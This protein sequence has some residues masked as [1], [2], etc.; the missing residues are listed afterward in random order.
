[1]SYRTILTC[2][3]TTKTVSQGTGT[4]TP[5]VFTFG[6]SATIGLRLAKSVN[7]AAVETSFDVSSLKASVGLVDARPTGGTWRLKIGP[8]AQTN[9]NT[10]PAQQANAPANTIASA[11]NALTGI[12]ATYGTATVTEQDGSWLITFA[13]ATAAVPL[14]VVANRLTPVSLGRVTAYEV[15]GRWI[16]ELRLIQTP[17]AFTSTSS[18]VLPDAPSIERI[19]AGGMESEIEFNE[20]QE[21]T[22]PQEFR[23]TYYLK[24]GGVRTGLLS[25]ADGPDEI[26]AALAIYGDGFEVTNPRPQKARIEFINDLGGLP[27]DLFEVHVADVPEGDLTFTLAFDRAELAAYLRTAAVAT[28]PLEVRLVIEDQEIVAFVVP[29]SIRRPVAF[30]ELEETPAIDWLRP[31]SPTQY[32]AYDPTQTLEGQKFYPAE[33]GDGEATVIPISHGLDTEY[34]WVWV[35]ENTNGGR[36]LI[37]GTDFTVTINN[38]NEVTVTALDGAPA[39]NA[40]LAIVMSANTVAHFANGLTVG[41]DQVTDLRDLLDA[42]G[43]DI[44]ELQTLL[45]TNA[46]LASTTAV[47]ALTI[48]FPEK[49]EVLFTGETDP[50]RLPARGPYLLPAVHKASPVVWTGTPLPAAAAESVWANGSGDRVLIPGG[51]M[52]RSG[53]AGSSLVALTGAVTATKDSAAVSGSGTAFTT[54]LFAGAMIKIGSDIYQVLSIT[55]ATALTLKTIAAANANGVTAYALT[56]YF[57]SDGRILYPASRDGTSTS[58]YPTAFE[59]TLWNVFVNEKQFASGTTLTAWF[60]LSLQLIAATC[61]A[62]WVLVIEK[63]TAPQDA[64]PATPGLNLH[65][66]DWDLTTPLVKQRL[67]LTPNEETHTFGCQ[68]ARSGS[69]FTANGYYYKQIVAVASPGITSGDIALRARLIQ[70]DTENAAVAPRGWVRYSLQKITGQTLGITIA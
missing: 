26:K 60:K 47:E 56:G 64:S 59:R 52:I 8:G 31:L 30:P 34:V 2:N 5:P 28:L 44:T 39:L 41:I 4:W 24:W 50:A 6:E 18:R 25:T 49:T 15:D 13:S 66:I 67:I 7:G 62:Q 42:M 1:M 51:G 65:D 46:S 54:E 69:T 61:D 70:F 9:A 37:D 53:Y 11:I 27:Q 10:I 43:A 16:N 3:L 55:S 17:V 32:I 12:V 36:Q 14:T 19:A 40:W 23:G 29:V 63:G 48:V 38:A 68:I 20:V 35:R 22:V 21:L 58:Y 33:I 45:P 57:A